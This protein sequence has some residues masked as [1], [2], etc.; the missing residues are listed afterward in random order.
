MFYKKEKLPPHRIALL[1]ELGFEWIRPHRSQTNLS[2]KTTVAVP[3][4][5]DE[6]DGDVTDGGSLHS[7]EHDQ[8]LIPS[9]V[10]EEEAVLV[11]N[12][13][14]VVEISMRSHMDPYNVIAFV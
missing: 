10:I 2:K 11:N 1:E 3:L 8:Q 12:P 14:E 5:T 7:R 4:I 9:Q 6:P 13:P